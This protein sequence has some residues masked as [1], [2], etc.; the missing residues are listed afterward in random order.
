MQPTP[1]HASWIGFKN[2]SLSKPPRT[3]LPRFTDRYRLAETGLEVSPFCLGIVNSEDTICDAF[4]SGINFF[5]VSTDLHWPAYH[6]VRRG[7]EK[8]FDRTRG[9]RER[10][11]VAAASYVT[12][13]WFFAGAM[14]EL[15]AAVRGLKTID[16]ATMGGVYPWHFTRRLNEYVESRSRGD[17]GVKAIAASFHDRNTALFAMNRDLVN[18]SLVRYNPSHPG[19]RKDLFPYLTPTPSLLFNFKSTAGYLE[20]AKY[21]ELGL[22]QSFWLPK[23]T[24]Y[25]RFALTRPEIAGLLCSPAGPREIEELAEAL[26][27]GPLNEEEENHLTCLAALGEGRAELNSNKETHSLDAEDTKI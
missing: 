14:H 16:V 15:V 24:D 9:M 8:L 21:A 11:V 20:P 23:I 3:R 5:F 10:V 26:E 2:M 1:T 4:D 18:L 13:P 17:L 7:L 25:Y 12:Q 19:A 6:A 27:E 22:D